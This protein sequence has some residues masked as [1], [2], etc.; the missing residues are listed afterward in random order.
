MDSNRSE[1]LNVAGK[2]NRLTFPTTSYTL[3]RIY[4][5]SFIPTTPDEEHSE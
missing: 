1:E 4:T 2:T 5:P 3:S